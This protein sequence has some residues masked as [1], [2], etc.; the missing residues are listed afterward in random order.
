MR[1]PIFESGIMIDG[2]KRRLAR[3][4]TRWASRF[5][6]SVDIS[7]ISA[8]SQGHL[9][10]VMHVR[11]PSDSSMFRGG[12]PSGE[13]LERNVKEWLN[14]MTVASNHRVKATSA[15]WSGVSAVVSMD[16]HYF[17]DLL[18]CAC[19]GLTEACSDI[20]GLIHARAQNGNRLSG[21][22][23]A[24][25]EFFAEVQFS[26]PWS[27]ENDD[28]AKALEGRI[29]PNFAN[30]T[31][32]SD[33]ATLM[34]AAATAGNIPVARIL[35]RSGGGIALQTGDANGC[36]PIHWVARGNGADYNK[37]NWQRRFIDFALT[38]GGDP[39]ARSI[40]GE[41]PLHVAAR[42]RAAHVIDIFILHGADPNARDS[43]G[44][45]PMDIARKAGDEEAV[46]ALDEF[47]DGRAL[48]A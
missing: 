31:R 17:S 6:G 9:K 1:N 13:I 34:H 12:T 19:D 39:N 32:R 36:T 2:L 33:K 16:V 37:R 26:S 3:A 42:E 4:V 18:A 38:A 25:E 21:V 7:G 48:A 15:G 22:R 24:F 43:R 20:E 28:L 47:G 30:M 45:T 41:T 46:A 23:P 14:S 44:R 8:M 5:G 10:A 40:S 35:L 11:M 27:P 29:P